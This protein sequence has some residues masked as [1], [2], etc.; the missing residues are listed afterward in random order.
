MMKFFA[1]RTSK[2]FYSKALVKENDFSCD[3]KDTHLN[4]TLLTV[5]YFN[6]EKSLSFIYNGRNYHQII[7]N[8]D[9]LFDSEMKD[10]K[11]YG[12]FFT[13]TFYLEDCNLKIVKYPKYPNNFLYEIILTINSYE[14]VI[15]IS[16]EI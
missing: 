15:S 11:Y 9:D 3:I 12:T 7:L 5:N 13:R 2:N 6:K 14:N 10:F 4:K 1:I 8:I 16:F